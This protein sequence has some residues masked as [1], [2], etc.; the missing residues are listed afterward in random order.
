MACAVPA[1][2]L[3]ASGLLARALLPA[4]AL[5]LPV[6][7][8][9][10]LPQQ[11]DA[12]HW[13]AANTWHRDARHNSA[14]LLG[15][16]GL[17]MPALIPAAALALPLGSTDAMAQLADAQ[18]WMAASDALLLGSLG[19]SLG[20]SLYTLGRQADALVQQQLTGAAQARVSR[21]CCTAD[22]AAACAT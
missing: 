6:N 14:V 1:A 21:P 3:A 17:L 22:L 2:A 8:E 7:S 4:A 16:L 13:P 15:S 20:D 19:D 5:D 9:E 11:A 12:Q 10:A 18:Q